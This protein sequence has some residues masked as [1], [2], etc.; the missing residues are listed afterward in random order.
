[1]SAGKL[2]VDCGCSARVHEDGSGV[3]MEYCDLH[4]AASDLRDAIRVFADSKCCYKAPE[5]AATEYC[6]HCSVCKAKLAYKKATGELLMSP[7]RL[8]T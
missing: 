4:E 5:V 7:A 3:E 2:L 8:C 6:G 1:M